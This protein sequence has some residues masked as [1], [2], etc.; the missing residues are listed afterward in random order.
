MAAISHGEVEKTLFADRS[1]RLPAMGLACA[2]A[3]SAWVA[4]CGA[5]DRPDPYDAFN[6]IAD[7][8]LRED[9]DYVRAHLTPELLAELSDPD[10]TDG[11]RA[12]R[13]L[14]IELQRFKAVKPDEAPTPEAEAVVTAAGIRRTPDGS[15]TG[16]CRFYMRSVKP[17][18][19]QLASR[20]FDWKPLRPSETKQDDGP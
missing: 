13:E 7:R 15:E 5:P 17:D 4:G 1:R 8:C 9:A 10:G 3:L 14:M 18:G 16:R 20:A 19:W 11:D 12:V 6:T 2:A